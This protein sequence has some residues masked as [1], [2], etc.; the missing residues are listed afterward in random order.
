M[1]HDE[2]PEIR[3]AIIERASI[4]NDDH[5]ILTAW[6]YL[7]YGGKGQAFGGYALH[8]GP[9]SR[10]HKVNSG[11]AG[12]FIWRVL[13]IAGVTEWSKVAGRTIRVKQSHTKCHAIGHIVKDDW[14]DPSIDFKDC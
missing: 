10:F 8:V 2:T 12:H 1:N 11:Y 4:T 9:L 7:D 13:E 3:N 14:F 6:L 5:G